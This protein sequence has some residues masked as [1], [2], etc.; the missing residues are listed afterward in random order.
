MAVQ[1]LG[2]PGNQLAAGQ[3]I[4]Q[5]R[6]P[7]PRPQRGGI[8]RRRTG[9]ARRASSGTPAPAR[10]R[11]SGRAAASRP[12]SAPTS[13]RAARESAQ[14]CAVTTCPRP[15][16]PDTSRARPRGPSGCS[17]EMLPPAGD[18]CAC[19]DQILPGRKPRPS[20]R[21]GARRGAARLRQC[22]GQNFSMSIRVV[23]R[24]YKY[25][26][27]PTPQQAELLNRTFGSVRYVYNRALAERSQA[28]LSPRTRG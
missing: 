17:T 10:P 23:K 22:H 2:Q 20:G 25:R 28:T 21:G 5:Q 12:R 4:G 11:P 18:G 7:G 19:R 1:V 26:F 8:E 24:A 14:A 9:R 6:E 15:S 13:P 27:Y 3:R 16:A